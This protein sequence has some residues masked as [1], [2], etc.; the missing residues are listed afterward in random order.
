MLKYWHF[1]KSRERFITIS[2]V[3]I[4]TP[5]RVFTVRNY[6]WGV[7][8]AKNAKLFY[9]YY[10]IH[11]S[12]STFCVWGGTCDVW[13]ILNRLQ[14]HLKDYI[15]TNCEKMLFLAEIFMIP[16]YNFMSQG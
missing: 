14:R 7:C 4:M 5:L 9:V 1:S 10:F 13:L 2:R 15:F 3:D 8:V 6:L 11:V 16:I 12:F